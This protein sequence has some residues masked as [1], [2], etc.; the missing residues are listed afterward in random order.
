MDRRNFLRDLVG[1]LA[2][3]AVVRSFPFRVFS[4]PSEIVLPEVLLISLSD[5]RRLLW[6]PF[7]VT[8]DEPIY[9]Y[10]QSYP[11]VGPAKVVTISWRDA[12]LMSE[13][14]A[15]IDAGHVVPI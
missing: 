3:T 12:T 7:L 15:L 6:E 10:C 5:A 4:F 13:F 14:A 9:H 1:G 11:E 2:A 8:D